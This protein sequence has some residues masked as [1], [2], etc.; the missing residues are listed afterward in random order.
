[1][2]YDELVI[3]ATRNNVII[4]E[5]RRFKSRALALINGNIIGISKNAD[6]SIKKSCLLAEELGHFY[7]STG[8]ILDQKDSTNRKQEYRARLWSYDKQIGLQG[9]VSAYKARCMN[10]SDIAEHLGVTE[11]FLK[12]AIECYRHKYGLAIKLDNYVIGFEPS[13]Y[14][15]E[16]LE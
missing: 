8:N 5:N 11:G 2:T 12:E 15:I 4:K 16:M 1:M 7:T 14:V 13:L 9:I 3:E 6:T 10:K